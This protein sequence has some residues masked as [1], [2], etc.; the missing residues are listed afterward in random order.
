ML[1]QNLSMLKSRLSDLSSGESGTSRFLYLDLPNY[2]CEKMTVDGEFELIP[3]LSVCQVY[4]SDLCVKSVCQI[5]M[6]DLCAKSVY[7]ICESDPYV[8]SVC[9]VCVSD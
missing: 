3:D 4:I 1:L 8:R 7:Q 6:S 9:Q 2:P 5:R